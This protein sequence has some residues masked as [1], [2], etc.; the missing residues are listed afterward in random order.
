[1]HR[2]TT[3]YLHLS[4]LSV[5]MAI[6][7]APY[8]EGGETAVKGAGWENSAGDDGQNRDRKVKKEG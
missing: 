6:G 2:R 5:T 3:C 8:S 1:M 7:H 4:W